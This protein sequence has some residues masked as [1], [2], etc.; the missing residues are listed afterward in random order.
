MST[1]SGIPFSQ[2]PGTPI[3]TSSTQ[4]SPAH[5]GLAQD[6][7][8]MLS[9]SPTI[10]TPVSPPSLDHSQASPPQTC[11]PAPQDGSLHSS[12]VGRSQAGDIQA[13]ASPDPAWLEA[14]PSLCPTSPVQPEASSSPSPVSQLRCEA[15]PGPVSPVQSEISPSPGPIGPVLSCP[16]SPQRHTPTERE[17]AATGDVSM[18]EEQKERVRTEKEV[19]ED[20]DAPQQQ[21]QQEEEEMEEPHQA[22]KRSP[23]EKESPKR[24]KE[25]GEEEVCVPAEVEQEHHQSPPHAP[26]ASPFQ[27]A[28]PT[29]QHPSLPPS[30]SPPASPLTS[31]PS[32]PPSPYR[33]GSQ[34]A[35]PSSPHRNALLPS[36]SPHT[37]PPLKDPPQEQDPRE[38]ETMKGLEGMQEDKT[39]SCHGAVDGSQS[40][41]QFEPVALAIEPTKD[42]HQ[43]HA[44][45]LERQQE[46]T[47][48]SL[49]VTEPAA[50]THEKVEEQQPII[51]QYS[52]VEEEQGEEARKEAEDQDHSD[53]DEEPMSPVLELDPS[54]DMEVMKLMSSSSPPPSFLH[55]SSP[56]PPP[57]SRRGK[58]RTLRPPPCSSRPSDDLSIRLRQSPFSTE[59]SPETSPARTPMTPP[60]LSP[61]SPHHRASPSARE[62]PPLSKLQA[63]PTT[64]LPL[65]PKIGM[66]KPAIT[67]RKFSPGRARIKQVSW[68]SNRRAVSPPSSS[69][70][71]TGEGGWDS[72][73]PLPPDSPLWSM[74]VGRGSGF[75][76]RRRSRGG[77][78]G[79]GRGGRGRSRLKTQDSLPVSP[80]SVYV[81]PFQPKEEEENSMHN[82]VVMFSTSDHFTLRQDMCVVCGSFGQG[83]EGRLLACSQCGQ[84]Y[85]PYCV[86]VKI[87]RVILT[88]GWRCLECTVCEAC[89][90]ASDPG[91]LLLCDDC[92]ISYHTYCLDPPLH[93]VPKGSWKCKWWVHLSINVTCL[94][95]TNQPPMVVC[96]L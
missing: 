50:A 45:P 51:E 63:P 38:A 52:A 30:P 5:S 75:P 59:A 65:T 58:G 96:V 85:H 72:P 82:T 12:P 19:E 43:S 7:T 69:Q 76:G 77:S 61:P 81:E 68:W 41:N 73:K 9:S 6:N 1:V 13:N 83:A 37:P 23:E 66:G 34:E 22:T 53:L 70:D 56:S 57:F 25:E 26:A 55:L 42:K 89:G 71:S 78:I 44:E 84:C 27:Q 49:K 32:P 15:S 24:T 39:L 2:G 40:E 93:T 60:P 36:C 47:D 11:P 4:A 92:D 20:R 16:S 86:N 54:L 29:T 79:G 17:S 64:V 94:F 21:Q 31:P 3:N 87:T 14:S 35:S 48:D 46:E 95:P 28:P 90:E 18:L 74:R 8:A 88:K 80:G 10:T 33:A 91:R 67:K 62:S